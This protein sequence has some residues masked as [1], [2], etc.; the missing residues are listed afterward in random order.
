MI[1]YYGLDNG[2][3]TCVEQAGGNCATIVSQNPSNT[4]DANYGYTCNDQLTN[5]TYCRCTNQ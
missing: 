3:P 2:N 5:W 4:S 1:M